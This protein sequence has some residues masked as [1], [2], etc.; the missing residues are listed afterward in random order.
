MLGL[1]V[2]GNVACIEMNFDV[3]ALETIHKRVHFVRRHQIAIKKDVLDIEFDFQFFGCFNSPPIA[4]L[5]R[6]SQTAFETGS[7]SSRQE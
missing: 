5:A 3:F 1:L 6:W 7:W 4:S 2:H